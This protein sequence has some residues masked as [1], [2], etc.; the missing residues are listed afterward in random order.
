MPE[1]AVPQELV[2]V[3]TD[4]FEVISAQFEVLLGFLERPE[5]LWQIAALLLIT[6]GALILSHM[7][8]RVAYRVAR[9]R[10]RDATEE[11][12]ERVNE[13]L[14]P[15]IDQLYFPIVALII[16]QIVITVARIDGRFVGFIE[17]GRMVFLLLL[18]YQVILTLLYARFS[19]SAVQRYHRY[20]FNFIVILLITRQL[21]VSFFDVTLL[22]N[23]ELAS[24]FDTPIRLG[25]L[26]AALL[27]IYVFVVVSWAIQDILQLILKTFNEDEG[28]VN[29]ILTITRYFVIVIGLLATLGALGFNVTTLVAVLG[30]LSVGIGLGLQKIV[31]NFF[32]GIVLLLEQSLRPGDWIE[33]NGQLGVVDRLNIRATTMRL[34]NN[35]EVIIPNENFLTSPVTTYNTTTARKQIRVD[36]GVSYNSNPTQVRDLMLDVVGRHG[37]VFQDPE[38]VVFFIEFGAS[39]L[40]FVLFGW[41]AG[42][43]VQYRVQSDLRYMIWEE[44]KKA[45]IEIPFPQRDVNLKLSNHELL[46]QLNA[47]RMP[48]DFT[49]QPETKDEDQGEPLDETRHPS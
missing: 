39:S 37:L 23:I 28:L 19:R 25:N 9:V 14:L 12:R 29:S 15:A 48:P 11:T 3:T 21:L 8:A 44:F 6:V 35:L 34:L 24:L 22:G 27:I 5:F 40:N 13:R 49:P 17:Q 36:V 18:G 33:F 30:G 43:D 42:R 7:F 4:A 16:T 38:P 20:V 45:G 47:M 26:L 46:E 41:V 32:S 31:S 2:T 10:L 1:E